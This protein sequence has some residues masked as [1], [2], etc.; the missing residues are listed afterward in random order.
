M[1]ATAALFVGMVLGSLMGALSVSLAVMA[2][3]SE[4][5]YFLVKMNREQ[6]NHWNTIHWNTISEQ[7]RSQP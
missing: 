1:S 5:D 4:E 7:T 6:A 3:Y 2:K